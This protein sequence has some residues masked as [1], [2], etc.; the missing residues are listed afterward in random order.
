MSPSI[1]V[2]CLLAASES[3]KLWPSFCRSSV[4]FHSCV[5]RSG[6]VIARTRFKY[7]PDVGRTV[8]VM[9]DSRVGVRLKSH[10][11]CLCLD[12]SMV[13]QQSYYSLI[14]Q[15][16]QWANP[17]PISHDCTSFTPRTL[18]RYRLCRTPLPYRTCVVSTSTRCSLLQLALIDCT[19]SD[20]LLDPGTMQQSA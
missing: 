9:L 2:Y 15:L 12:S 18:P 10:H 1:S 14:N 6:P 5:G 20:T 17:C 7:M 19:G 16:N 4:K 13:P 11:L 8:A 3:F